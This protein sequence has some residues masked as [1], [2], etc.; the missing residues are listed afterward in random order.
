[1]GAGV[2]LKRNWRN[3]RRRSETATWSFYILA[4]HYREPLP[5]PL[6]GRGWPA[7]GVFVSRGRTG[8]GVKAVD[9]PRPS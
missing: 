9:T 1:M 2:V 4:T 5:S 8:E 3:S 6:W 7:T